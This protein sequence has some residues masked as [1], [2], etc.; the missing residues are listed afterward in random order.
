MWLEPWRTVLLLIAALS[1]LDAFES[2][3]ALGIVQMAI[4]F[5]IVWL[6][7]EVSAALCPDPRH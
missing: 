7:L 6:C 4:A 5:H 3:G 2:M 1:S